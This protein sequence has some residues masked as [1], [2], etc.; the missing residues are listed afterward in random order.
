MLEPRRLFTAMYLDVTDANAMPAAGGGGHLAAATTAAGNND[1]DA[2][3]RFNS[4]TV[5]NLITNANGS[6][7]RIWD[8]G[9]ST[10]L[11]TV[12]IN[13]EIV[14]LYFP[15]GRYAVSQSLGLREGYTYVGRAANDAIQRTTV[16][17]SPR[18]CS[19][20]TTRTLTLRL[21]SIRTILR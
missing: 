19:W 16:S 4:L 15:A 17:S 13:D 18:L 10:T 20:K 11:E 7:I 8:E 3:N 2:L 6:Q 1:F 9:T 5:P 14:G 21:A 12:D